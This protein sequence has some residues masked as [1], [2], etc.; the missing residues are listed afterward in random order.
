MKHIKQIAET[1]C[2]YKV[3]IIFVFQYIVLCSQLF[4]QDKNLVQIKAFDQQLNPI[5]HLSVS[6]NGNEFI[7]IESKSTFHEI[8]IKDLPPKFIKI[9]KEELEAESWNYSKGTLEIVIRK[10]NYKIHVIHVLNGEDKPLANLTVNFNGK[11]SIN[12]TTD[13]RGKIEI[14][15]SLDEAIKV[16]KF[17]VSGYRILKMVPSE[18]GTTLVLEPLQAEIKKQDIPTEKP[19][20]IKNFSLDQLDSISSLT[21]FY[22]VFK[23]YEISKLDDDVKFKIDAKFNQL[24]NKL[25]TAKSKEFISRISDSSFV[26]NDVENLLEQARFENKLL[27][28]FRSEFDEKIRIL[29]QKLA[30]GTAKLDALE[31][32]KLLEDLNMLELVLQQNENKFYKNIND[33]RI[34]LASLKASFFDIQHLENKLQLSES[35][36]KEEQKLFQDKILIAISIAFVFG[37]LLII[38][39]LLRFKL[40]KQKKN[41]IQANNE[42]KHTND[43][44]EKLIYERTSLLIDAYREMDIFL[45]RSSHDLRSPICSIIGLCN[46]A[47]HEH[48]DLMDLINKISF[49]AFRMDR[50]LNKLKLISEINQPSNYTLIGLSDRIGSIRTQFQQFITDKKIDIIIDCPR[51]VSFYSYANLIETIFYNL[52]DNALFF[53]SINSIHPKVLIKARLD[54]NILIISVHDNGIG[55]KEEVRRRLWDMFFVG[56]EYSKG[57]G[58]GLYIV[59]KCVQVLNGQIDLQTELYKFTIFTVTIPVNTTHTSTLTN[60][61]QQTVLNELS[62]QQ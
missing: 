12:T 15:L 50:M 18:Q 2:K 30:G 34:I 17:S 7:P 8:L 19:E 5:Y 37:V 42:V 3:I 31:R 53:S 54:N 28:N 46:L 27:N 20:F 41:L 55:I 39:I 33:Y 61:R 35:K 60:S 32:N 10:R 44:L 57:N 29:N 11:K 38:L 16:D 52:I 59:S 21:V 25:N 14:P 43:N 47:Y 62:Y 51:R 26:N 13:E 4:A 6:I 1:M 48:A 36:R 49:T 56:N 24:V 23:N 9:N 45:Y 22:A 40:E 58:L